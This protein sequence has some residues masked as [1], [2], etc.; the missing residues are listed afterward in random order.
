MCVDNAGGDG[1]EDD[2][3]SGFDER[4]LAKVDP[5]CALLHTGLLRRACYVLEV[6][7]APGAV[8]PLLALLIK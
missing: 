2:D 5:L 8:K 1:G 6:V 4:Q 7:H 3:D